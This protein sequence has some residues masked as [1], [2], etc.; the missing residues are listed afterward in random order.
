M[1]GS[2]DYLWIILVVIGVILIFAWKPLMGMF[3]GVSDKMTNKESYERGREVFYDTEFWAGEGSYK[4][5]AMCH[6]ADFV[7][8]EGK[9]IDMP[10]YKPG[11]PWILKDIANKYGSNLLSGDDE[12]FN[13][14]MQCLSSPGK[15]GM[16]RPSRN[17][18]Y[19]EDL[20][21]YVKRQ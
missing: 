14:M 13:R 8:E 10:E 6:A 1:K 11:E 4:S 21:E 18:P 12:L 7:P 16:G 3:T 5:C 15:M 9:E 2:V 19:M 20:I 17:A